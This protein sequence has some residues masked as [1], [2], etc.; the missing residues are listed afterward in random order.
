[1]RVKG[2]VLYVKDAENF[3]LQAGFLT[4]SAGQKAGLLHMPHA[5]NLRPAAQAEVKISVATRPIAVCLSC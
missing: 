4:V 2:H 1:M 3:H 5:W